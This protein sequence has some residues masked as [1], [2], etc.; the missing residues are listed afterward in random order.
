M[1]LWV[2]RRFVDDRRVR[3]AGSRVRDH[4]YQT[5]LE[6]SPFPRGRAVLK[7]FPFQTSGWG[8]LVGALD[9]IGFQASGVQCAEHPA[10]PDDLDGARAGEVVAV[11]RVGTPRIH[12][13]V[14]A[15]LNTEEKFLHELLCRGDMTVMQVLD[16]ARL[17]KPVLAEQFNAQEA[18]SLIC[19]RLSDRSLRVLWR[20]PLAL[21]GLAGE[22][23]AEWQERFGESEGRP[24]T[25]LQLWLPIAIGVAHG[26]FRTLAVPHCA[27]LDPSCDLASY[28]K[29]H[30][31]VFT[32]KCCR[33]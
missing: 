22:R 28:L 26:L 7:G 18:P 31:H 25:C 11:L 16:C 12:N 20:A 5:C 3:L 21:G 13:N 27:R 14:F 9:A 1:I 32:N 8:T 15:S 4:T 23:V 33:F 30:G 19:F 10:D 6:Q 17:E 29:E 24:D 2:C